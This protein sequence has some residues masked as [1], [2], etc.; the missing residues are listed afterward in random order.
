[1]EKLFK[2]IIILLLI[3]G[4]VYLFFNFAAWRIEGIEQNPNAYTESGHAHSVKIK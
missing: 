2:N 4:G 1:M 3:F